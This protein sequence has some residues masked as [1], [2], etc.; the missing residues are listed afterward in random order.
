MVS[1]D[2]A[3]SGWRPIFWVN[4][5]IGVL[6]IWSAVRHLP[7]TRSPRPASPDRAG[8]VVLALAVL[9]LLVPLT[10]GRALGWPWW[11]W[12]LLGTAPALATGFVL[13]E[14]R[15]ERTSGSPLVPPSLLRVPSLRQGLTLLLALFTTFGAFMF[16]YALVFQVGLGFSPVD[17]G[18]ALAPM[19]IGFLVSSLQMARLVARHGRTVVTV[20]AVVQLVGIGALVLSLVLTWPAVRAQDVAAPFALMGLGQ[21]L[22]MPSAMRLALSDVPLQA[23][24]VAAGVLTTTQQVALALGV[25]TIGSLFLTL[26]APTHLGMGDAFLVVLS[27]QSL[28]AV[29]V[30]VGS[31]RLPGPAR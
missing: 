3:G 11:S 16:V 17:A 14:R 15:L 29:A 24:G 30:A 1:A 7:E 31:R 4:V 5:P 13:V 6:G 22:M 8:S 25:A 9:A 23:A 18:L 27:I 21:G 12:V 20:G 28:A 10:E 26:S 19:A 2:L